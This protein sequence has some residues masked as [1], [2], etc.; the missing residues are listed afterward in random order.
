MSVI[1]IKLPVFPGT[2]AQQISVTQSQINPGSAYLW[3]YLNTPLLIHNTLLHWAETVWL[4]ATTGQQHRT[5]QYC[6]IQYRPLQY[7]PFSITKKDNIE[8]LLFQY[9]SLDHV[10]FL[11][12][13]QQSSLLGLYRPVLLHLLGN[14]G[15][16]TPA[17]GPIRRINSSK[18]VLPGNQKCL[19][20]DSSWDIR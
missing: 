2:M 8:I 15:K 10:Y 14:T 3:Q 20:Y 17:A 12:L 18:I 11:V 9:C 13:P 1:V 4:P 16:Y 6:P 19:Y 5:I 7:S